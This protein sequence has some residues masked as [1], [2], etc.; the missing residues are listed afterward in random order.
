MFKRLAAACAIWLLMFSGSALADDQP[1]WIAYYSDEEEPINFEPYSVIVFEPDNHPLIEGLLESGKTVLGYLSLGEVSKDRFYFDE[2]KNQGLFLEENKNW[3]GAYFVDI[4]DKRWTKRVIEELIP[5]I[6]Y[7]RFSG[8]FIDTLD[9]AEHLEDANPQKYHGMRQA[10]IDLIKAIRLNYP[11]LKIM[12]NRG[13]KI[14]PSVAKDIDMEL[15]ES[16]YTDFNRDKGTYELVAKPLYEKNVKI[17]KEAQKINSKLEI[18]TLDY[19]NLN[20]KTG[21]KKIY[22]AERENGFV[23]Y[24]S[25]IDLSKIVPE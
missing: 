6:L 21:I 2:V 9:N 15:G 13:F 24:V 23:P 14:L 10:A 1:R 12:L 5:Q 17:L 3:K 22:Q 19:W 7:Q 25:T 8:I 16:I 11:S 4:R 18:Y 20:D